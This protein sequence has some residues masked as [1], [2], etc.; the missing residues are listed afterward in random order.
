MNQKPEIWVEIE[1]AGWIGTWEP[2]VAL[3]LFPPTPDDNA[4]VVQNVFPQ[5]FTFTLQ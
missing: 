5:H 4:I 3:A 2:I 1:N